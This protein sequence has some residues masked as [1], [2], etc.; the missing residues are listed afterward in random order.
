MIS[1]LFTIGFISILSQVI[2]L[3]ELAVASFGVEL[4]YILA[5]GLWLLFT[6]TGA[7]IGRRSSTVSLAHPVSLILLFTLLLPVEIVFTRSMRSFFGGV[8]GAFLPFHEQ[9]IGISLA[10]APVCL[11]LGA[12]FTWTARFSASRGFNLA[13]AYAIE[14]AGGV[15]GGIC[16]TLFLAFKLSNLNAGILCGLAALVCVIQVSFRLDRKRVVIASAAGLVYIILLYNGNA[17]DLMMTRW[18]HPDLLVTRDTPYSRITVTSADEQMSVFENDA[19]VFETGGTDAEEFTHLSAIQH[20]GPERMLLLG[21][22]FEGVLSGLLEHKPKVL[23]YIELNRRGFSLVQ[24]IMPGSARRAFEHD[25]VNIRFTDPRNWLMQDIGEYDLVMIGMPDPESGQTNRFYT[26]EFFRQV[27]ACLAP[28]GVTAFKLRAAENKWTPQLTRRNASIYSTLT[29]VFADVVVLPGKTNIMVA[30]NSRLS[31]DTMILKDRLVERNIQARLVSPRYVDY[32]YTNDRFAQIADLLDSLEA[33]VNL[34]SRPLCYQQ[35]ALMWLSRFYQ[36][37]AHAVIPDLHLK[38]FFSHPF[39]WVF[40]LVIIGIM[41]TARLTCTGNL[42]LLVGVAALVGMV[43]EST[44]LLY[45]QAKSGALFQNIGILVTAF[46]GGLAAGAWILQRCIGR[47]SNSLRSF[48]IL[49]MGLITG[50]AFLIIVI[51][52]RITELSLGGFTGV[53]IVLFM[54]GSFVAG[55]FA[56]ASLSGNVKNKLRIRRLYASDMIGASIGAVAGSLILIPMIGLTSS[57]VIM[58]CMLICAGV[59]LIW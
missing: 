28:G 8:P 21:G 4:V 29:A 18:N 27:S 30:S 7:L 15:A 14:S 24:G 9:I 43:V 55:I 56:Y 44:L 12:S 2:L 35:T 42:I 19:L 52:S 46:M 11:I 31:R 10:L 48:R 34:D 54:V 59:I 6:G 32:L 47:L 25:A 3:R 45:Y 36:P 53:M 38:Q 1:I 50:F 37:L 51:S 26:E 23:D 16:S 40:F 22:G 58:A 33:P 20:P 17:L 13:K 39:S 41:L 5:L 57:L 49:G